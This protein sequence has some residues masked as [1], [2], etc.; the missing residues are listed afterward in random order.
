MTFA[1][2]NKDELDSMGLP[3]I[4]EDSDQ[5]QPQTTNKG[6][7]IN[8]SNDYSAKKGDTAGGKRSKR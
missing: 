4:D 1:G 2:S 7:T 6:S 8:S 5:D 3:Q